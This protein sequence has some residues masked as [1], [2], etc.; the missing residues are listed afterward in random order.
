MGFFLSFSSEIILSSVHYVR[1]LADDISVAQGPTEQ[2][3]FFFLRMDIV[4]GRW[5]GERGKRW[6][7]CFVAG[8][9]N[10]YRLDGGQEPLV[11]R[12]RL[13]GACPLILHLL[14]FLFI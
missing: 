1:V 2:R 14:R 13:F 3:S 9:F 5:G 12:S 11:R 8:S 6:G 4:D 10:H 7:V